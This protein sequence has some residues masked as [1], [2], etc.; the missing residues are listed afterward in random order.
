MEEEVN[1]ELPDSIILKP[2]PVEDVTMDGSVRRQ[3][4]CLVTA[5]EP[6][7]MPYFSPPGSWKESLEATPRAMFEAQQTAASHLRLALGAGLTAGQKRKRDVSEADQPDEEKPEIPG[8]AAGVQWKAG[9]RQVKQ[10]KAR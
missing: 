4:G 9:Q 10:Q 5:L 2:I 3:D 6:T 8:A 7:V 1:V